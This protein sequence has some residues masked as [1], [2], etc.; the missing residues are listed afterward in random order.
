MM[1][2]NFLALPLLITGLLLLII[3]WRSWQMPQ[4]AGTRPFAL[5]TLASA[6][7]TLGYA[8]ELCSLTLSSL[9][10]WLKLE[11][12][13]GCLLP[14]LS[15]SLALAY[16]RRGISKIWQITLFLPGL[17]LMG[18]QWT[19]AWHGLYY[20]NMRLNTAGPFPV[21]EFVKGPAYT[22]LLVYMALSMLASNYLYLRSWLQAAGPQRRSL[23]LLLA[24]S[25]I[26]WLAELIYQVWSD[27]WH[28]DLTPFG[29]VLSSLLFYWG[30]TNWRLFNL[31]PIVRARLFEQLSDG[32]LVLD[33]N[34]RIADFNPAALK[35]LGLSTESLGQPL[36]QALPDWP[37]LQQL[38]KQASQH[39]QIQR[40]LE[41]KRPHANGQ[42]WFE[43]D[44]QHLSRGSQHG[45]MMV[46][47]DI[48]TR[49]LTEQQ[50]HEK[51]HE[52]ET[53]RDLAS[54]MARQAEAAN[55]AKSEFLA[56]MSHELRTPLNGVIGL[57]QLLIS[58]ELSADQQRYAELLGHSGEA[59]LALINDILDLAKIEARQLELELLPFN[60]DNEMQKIRSILAFQ[61]QEKGLRLTLQINSDVPNQLYGD[62]GRLRQILLNLGINAI[63]FTE[64]GTVSLVVSCEP[65]SQTIDPQDRPQARLRFS[66][67]D[68]G[69]GI[70]AAD[71]NRLFSPFTQLDGSTTRKYGGT[72]LGLAISRQLVDLMG[73]ELSVSSQPGQG[74]CFWFVSNF[75]I[76]PEPDLISS[77]NT[78]S[79]TTEHFSAR[80]LLAEDN[81]INQLVAQTLLEKLGCR[82]DVVDN[83]LAVLNT[84][85]HQTYDLILMDC[86]MPEMDGFETTQHIR[87]N[88]LYPA[89]TI[90]ALTAHVQQG[91]RE[92]CLAA[93]M[94]DYL[95]KP[96]QQQALI[97]ILERWLDN[98]VVG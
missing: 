92:R 48:S 61:A 85:K 72:G 89:L 78:H 15:V 20:Q 6:V 46:I 68:T 88:N 16:T 53:A 25:L 62:P 34:N 83:G 36:N 70:A 17:V 33:Q 44:L 91:D 28:L 7:Y 57:S 58:T 8:G 21:A 39:T 76:Q 73:G 77:P 4:A 94:N 11:Y 22:L 2:F 47:H 31:S 50:L 13:G 3:A 10:T 81:P 14:G 64:N 51:N 27:G 86:Q 40:R 63:K 12:L 95:S 69:I 84:L 67:Q 96:I 97:K 1:T 60:L 9:Q 35:L 24:G 65:V 26:P 52:L 43:L 87:Q 82:V 41:I 5:L 59:L 80:I 19:N 49:K 38:S 42:S 74:S 37:E 71:L 75:E 29:L 66:V 18:L 54:A 79:P 30:L 93:G 23:S 32:V 45:L 98:R 55:Q 56:N 90:V